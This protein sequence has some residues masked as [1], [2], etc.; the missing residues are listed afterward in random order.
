MKYLPEHWL[1]DLFEF[2]FTYLRLKEDYGKVI[3]NYP[4]NYVQNLLTF[5]CVV[6]CESELISNP[7]TK[8][9][10]V[11]LLSFFAHDASEM[12]L[13]FD[14]NDLAKVIAIFLEILI[15]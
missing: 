9:K 7:Y 11:E 13:I 2:H 1:T 14:N 15:L 8:A 10:L 4:G 12:A 3:M 5:V 6:L